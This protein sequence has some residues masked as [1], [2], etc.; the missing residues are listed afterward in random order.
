M[1]HAHNSEVDLEQR[2][3]MV[4]RPTAFDVACIQVVGYRAECQRKN[5]S[6]VVS[7]VVSHVKTPPPAHL[8]LSTGV[9][10]QKRVQ[11]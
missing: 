2:R 5:L 8:C 7:R 4:A 9:N 1:Y 3:S 6:R 10:S 11:H